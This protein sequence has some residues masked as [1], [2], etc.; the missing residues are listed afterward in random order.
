M[1]PVTKLLLATLVVMF[2]QLAVTVELPMV[3]FGP[4]QALCLGSVVCSLCHCQR[5]KKKTPSPHPKAPFPLHKVYHWKALV[6][7]FQMHAF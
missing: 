5:G 6:D 7:S 3:V 1:T 4:L 2:K